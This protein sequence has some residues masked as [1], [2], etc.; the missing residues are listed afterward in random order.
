M[1][2]LRIAVASTPLTATLEEILAHHSGK[3]SRE[4]NKACERDN[5]MSPKEA[6]DFGLI[7]EIVTRP[8]GETK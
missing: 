3:S 2:T 8:G 5:F 4:V 1:T 7:D 6:K